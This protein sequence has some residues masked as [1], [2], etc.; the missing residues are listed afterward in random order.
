MP[1]LISQL[2]T[3]FFDET[4]AS[5]ILI[6]MGLLFIATSNLWLRNIYQRFM[7]RRYENMEG[8]RDSRQK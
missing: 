6:A 1:F 7:K 8:F 4:T 2:L 5:L 3:G